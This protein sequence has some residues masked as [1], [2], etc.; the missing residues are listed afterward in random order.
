MRQSLHPSFVVAL[1]LL[2][3]VALSAFA[4]GPAA[5]ATDAENGTTYEAGAT[6]VFDADGD[7]WTL[8][9]AEGAFV[10]ARPVKNGTVE[11]DT[12]T[13]RN[14]TYRL[15]DGDG[16]LRYRFSITGAEPDT[17]DSDGGSADDG[18]AEPVVPPEP[19]AVENGTRYEVGRTLRFTLPNGEYALRLSGGLFVQTL[20]AE[21]GT[22]QLDT[23]ELST[24]EYRLHGPNGTVRYRFELGWGEASDCEGP[25]DADPERR[26]PLNA[27]DRLTFAVD[28]PGFYT[29]CGPDGRV[30]ATSSP[31]TGGFDTDR[32]T[33]G[34]YR[35]QDRAGELTA[36][37]ELLRDSGGKDDERPPAG[38]LVAFENGTAYERGNRIAL[39]TESALELRFEGAFVAALEANATVATRELE[40]G[41][42]RLVDDGSLEGAFRVLA[43]EAP[44]S[45]VDGPRRVWAGA[46]A[47]VGTNATDAYTLWGPAS[48]PV[49]R[50]ASREGNVT[51]DTDGRRGAYIL[52]APNGTAIERLIVVKQRLDARTDG[53]DLVVTSNRRDYPLEITVEGADAA[54]IFGSDTVT[55]NESERLTPNTTGIEPGTYLVRFSSADASAAGNATFRIGSASE[56]AT[57][58][59][60]VAAPADEATRTTSTRTTTE[61]TTTTTPSAEPANVTAESPGTPGFGVLGAL[62]ALLVGW[63]SKER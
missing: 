7:E 38:S 32:L 30:G 26:V 18:D 31:E 47:T 9:N 29:L 52:T 20:V 60:A 27:T 17:D 35:L 42:Y 53:G 34:V 25:V 37:V 24:A 4:A 61:R 49:E 5:A 39:D 50:F 58:D 3:L 63:A 57:N 12:G 41:T 46:D 2:A 16:T 48:L 6:L 14:G 10:S 56:N 8:R 33:P 45:V 36:S 59:T 62:L 44:E 54:D 23:G 22:A 11:I 21:D 55:A 40:A 43:A 15:L 19:A 28:E 51:V 13:L 1:A